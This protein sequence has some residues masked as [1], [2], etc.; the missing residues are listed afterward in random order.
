MEI[1]ELYQR[2]KNECP[3]CEF[4]QNETFEHIEG[5]NVPISYQVDFT[6]R[7]DKTFV[8]AIQCAQNTEEE[9]S[10]HYN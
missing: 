4:G 2:L 5:D 8:M 6:I 3:A 1:E 10:T 9:N 7:K